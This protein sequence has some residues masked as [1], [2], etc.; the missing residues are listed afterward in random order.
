MS[1]FESKIHR[2]SLSIQNS[3]IFLITISILCF[4]LKTAILQFEYSFFNE[5]FTEQFCENKAKP[6]LK[7]NG[8]CHLKKISKEQNE[9][10]S[11]K[12]TITDCEVTY[13]YVNQNINYIIVTILNKKRFFLN[14]DILKSRPYFPIDHPPQYLIIFLKLNSYIV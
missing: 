9:Q 13:L 6:E 2:V 3:Y 8:K 14:K 4:N 7:C 5:S 1:K 10:D 12:K 11:T